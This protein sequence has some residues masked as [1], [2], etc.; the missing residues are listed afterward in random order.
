M[1]EELSK[2]DL[3]LLTREVPDGNAALP[4]NLSDY[5]LDRIARDLDE[6]QA[7]GEQDASQESPHTLS[8]PLYLIIKIL[9]AKAGADKLKVSDEEMYGYFQSYQIEV[10]LEIVSRRTELKAEPASLHTIFTDRDVMVAKD[11]AGLSL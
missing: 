8:G 1:T 10:N 6:L 4:C 2:T 5:W 9:M 7:A 11:E 3:A